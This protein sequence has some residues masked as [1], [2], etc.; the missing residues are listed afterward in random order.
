MAFASA[1]AWTPAMRQRHGRVARPIALTSGLER[2]ADCGAEQGDPRGNLR[3]EGRARQLS[4][5]SVDAERAV[6]GS[7]PD[8][9][10]VDV[11]YVDDSSILCRPAAVEPLPVAMDNAA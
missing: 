2:V 1:T 10:F 7:T 3:W 11:W 4:G 9:P 5:V 8:E 6:L